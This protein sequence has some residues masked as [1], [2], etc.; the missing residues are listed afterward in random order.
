[1][2]R[3]AEMVRWVALLIELQTVGQP[4][5]GK[6]GV[7]GS[8]PD[9]DWGWRSATVP[10]I[11]LTRCASSVESF[12]V[13]NTCCTEHNTETF[14]GP[15]ILMDSPADLL[16]L[17][18]LHPPNPCPYILHYRAILEHTMWS[19]P[20]HKLSLCLKCPLLKF[21]FTFYSPTQMS[22][23]LESFLYSLAREN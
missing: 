3:W 18:S 9:R 12:L 23:C 15:V 6:M 2:R 13:F 5:T 20:L 7:H 19:M 14:M 1:M 16:S 10:V 4:E 8:L 11:P 22:L 17:I 21:P